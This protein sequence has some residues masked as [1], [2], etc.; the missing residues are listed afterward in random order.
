MRR[1]FLLVLIALLLVGGGVTARRML[2]VTGGGGSFVGPE[3]PPS[4]LEAFTITSAPE[5]GWVWFG[6]PRAVNLGTST[7]AGY[8]TGSSGG[9]VKNILIDNA[10]G[11]VTATETLYDNFLLDDHQPPAFGVRGDGTIMAAFA[12]H[13]GDIYIA[14]GASPGVLPEGA[15]VVNITSQLGGPINPATPYG[16][17]YSTILYLPAEDRWYMFARYHDSGQHPHCVMST[18]D[19]DGATWTTHTVITDITY[20]MAVVNGTDRIDLVLSD[21]P[22]YGQNDDPDEPTFIQHVYYESGTGWHKSDGTSVTLPVAN[23]GEATVVYDNSPDRAWLWGI[24]VDGSGN[25]VIVFVRYEDPY[26]TGPW[27]YGYARWNGSAWVVNDDVADA[28]GSIY[29]PPGTNDYAGGIAVDPEDPTR[30]LYSSDSSGAFQVYLGETPDGG[31]TWD[32]TQLTSDADK[33]VRP[34]WV[35]GHGPDLQALFLYGTYDDYF[36][37][38]QGIKGVRPTE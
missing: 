25:P 16:Y 37:Y 14:P 21:H 33:N 18:S 7:V 15:D 20:H 6:A 4:A 12:Y 3:L 8:T 9:D 11:A 31:A 23:S 22:F 38:S 29:D 24:A 13:V 19:D 32:V 36:N 27:H 28:G 34:V 26:P 17:T 5:G 10:T 2:L 35:T 1:G 30:I